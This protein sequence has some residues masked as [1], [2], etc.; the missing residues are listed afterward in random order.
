MGLTQGD[1]DI[2]GMSRQMECWF[3]L[4]VTVTVRGGC[5]RVLLLTGT[6]GELMGPM[7]GGAHGDRWGGDG[8]LWDPVG[9]LRPH[10]H[11]KKEPRA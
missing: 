5:L 1:V 4:L 7:G 9:V 11:P 2:R 8:Y 10:G 3:V 6:H